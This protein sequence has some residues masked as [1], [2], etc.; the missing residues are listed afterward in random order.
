MASYSHGDSRFEPFLLGLGVALLPIYAFGSGG[1][2]PAHA[3]LAFF[4]LIA[5]LRKGLPSETFVFFLAGVAIYS[6]FVESFY[7]AMG[8]KVTSLMT[9]VFFF[10]NLFVVSA[11]YSYCSRYGLSALTP[12]VVVAC[13]I[14]IIT[15][16]V[17]GVSLQE[18]GQGRATGAFNNPNQLGYFSVC[19]LSLTYL[20][21]SH[22]HLKY[23]V[24]VGMFAVAI[25]LSIASLSKAAMIANFVVAF[26]ALKP[27][28][29]EG[30]PRSKLLAIGFPI[31]WISLV[32]FGLGF[33]V[34]SYLQGSFDDYLFVKRFQNI[35]HEDD[36]S[37]DSQIGRAHV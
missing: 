15:I 30:E 20:L 22:G 37:L 16:S 25:F 31:F 2:Q 36:S 34:T 8:A 6:F 24:A 14:A 1:V 13:A 35:A 26:L 21:Y 11:I 9:S 4:S 3:V 28:R 23:I 12:G 32:V 7:V 10:Y 18:G 27:V 17:A 5:L 19:I 33:I 29:R